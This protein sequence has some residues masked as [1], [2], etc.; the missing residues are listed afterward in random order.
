MAEQAMVDT[1]IWSA[2][3]LNHELDSQIHT[4]D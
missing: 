2:F 1:L 3:Q 4:M